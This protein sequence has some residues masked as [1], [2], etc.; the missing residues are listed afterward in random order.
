MHLAVWLLA[1]LPPAWTDP[2]LNRKLSE[3]EW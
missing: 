2:I 3:R 1:A